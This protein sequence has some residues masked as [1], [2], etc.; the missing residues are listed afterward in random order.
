MFQ[1]VVDSGA[2]IPAELVR[3]YDIKVLSFVN[4]A[5]GRPLVCFDPELSIEEERA[6]GKE[7]YDAIRAGMTVQTGLIGCGE[8]EECFRSL[9]ENGDDVLCLTISSGI[10]GTFNAARLAAN[11]IN[12][13]NDDAEVHP[14]VR[15]IDT[16]NAS[17]ATGILAIYASEFRAKGMNIDEVVPLIEAMVPQINGVFTVGD[18]RYLA[19]TGRLTGSKALIG[20]LL[21]IK[22]ILRG[23]RDGYIV[24]FKKCHGRKAALNTLISLVCD[25]IVDPEGQI[26]GIAHADA[27]EESVYIMNEITKKVHVRGFINTT[28]DFCTGSHVGP[29]T[30][31]LF[32]LGKDRELGGEGLL[33]R[34]TQMVSAQLEALC[35]DGRIAPVPKGSNTHA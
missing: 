10:S 24:Q 30:I 17:L 21:S 9:M 28:Y 13:E 31:A 33:S 12:E 14:C 16:K 35:G 1:I 3:H 5:N 11:M 32:F 34:A 6:K 20:N 27:Y 18:L 4:I 19:K 8:F 7:Y 2:N 15:L 26:L 22:P 25:N 29:D 23:N